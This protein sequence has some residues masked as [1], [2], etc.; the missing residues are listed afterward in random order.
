MWRRHAHT[1]G[2]TLFGRD[3]LSDPRANSEA[4]ISPEN[5]RRYRA[6]RRVT[7]VGAVVN[8]FLALA[9]LLSG[10]LLNSQALIADGV[11]TLSDLITDGVVLFAAG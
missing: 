3:V 7:V 11:H 5:G 4:T 10:W 6:T 2:L 8:A 1:E 9:Q